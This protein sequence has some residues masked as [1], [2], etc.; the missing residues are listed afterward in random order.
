MQEIFEGMYTFAGRPREAA[1]TGK[2]GM[3]AP[4]LAEDRLLMVSAKRAKG[5]HPQCGLWVAGRTSG[6]ISLSS[7][8]GSAAISASV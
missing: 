8:W 2:E 4:A 5:F 3:R 7:D 6:P 1:D